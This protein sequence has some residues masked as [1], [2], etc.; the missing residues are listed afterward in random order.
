MSKAQNAGHYLEQHFVAGKDSLPY[1]ILFPE[2]FDE[3]KKYPV[4]FFLHGAGERGKDNKAQLVYGSKLFLQDEMRQKFPAIIIFP[5]CSAESYWSNVKV[6]TV[7]GARDFQFQKGGKPTL[8]MKL[9]LKL[10]E[11]FK[12]KK[13]TDTDRMYVGGLSMGGM[14]T[15][16][17]LRR[18]RNTFA[19]AFSICGGDNISHVKKY[20][21]VPLWLFHGGKDDVVPP[22]NSEKVVAALKSLGANVKYS[23]YPEANH[24]SWDQAFA[25]PDFLPWLF[26]FRKK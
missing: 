14:G 17:V 2:N 7:N 18:E 9:L 13:F 5:Q 6:E 26:S 25:E 10:V 21:K 4:L 8:A 24:N 22:E 23:F 16:E 11:D 3:S 20:R 19:V 1:R 15:L 12:D